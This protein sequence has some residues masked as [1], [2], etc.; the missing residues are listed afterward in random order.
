MIGIISYNT[1]TSRDL[2]FFLQEL[3]VNYILIDPNDFLISRHDS[4]IKYINLVLKDIKQKKQISQKLTLDKITRFTF[5]HNTSF[6]NI[7]NIADGCFLYP[8]CSV[9]PT[10]HIFQDSIVHSNARIS[11]DSSIGQGC[12]IG[13]NVN[14][15]GTVNIG[16]YCTLYPGANIADKVNIP[17]DTIIGAD[18]FIKKSI[19]ESG[20]YCAKSKQ[21]IKVK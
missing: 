19:I 3:N 12:F 10:V 17:D 18:T 16:K 9:Y 1:A 7:R 20:T 21:I 13:G 2:K 8:N 11:H 5:I 4:D 15:S 6:C 14:I